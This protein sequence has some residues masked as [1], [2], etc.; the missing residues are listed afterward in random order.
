MTPVL[1]SATLAGLSLGLPAGWLACRLYHEATW[2]T[3]AR[4]GDDLRAGWHRTLRK[5][6]TFYDGAQEAPDIYRE[7]S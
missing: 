2:E 3:A 6:P 4:V 7:V 1:I 5:E